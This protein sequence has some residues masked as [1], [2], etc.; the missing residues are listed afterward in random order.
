MDGLDGRKDVFIIGATN[1][2]DIIDGGMCVWRW[3]NVIN[4]KIM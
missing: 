1:R 3:R 4:M 2:P